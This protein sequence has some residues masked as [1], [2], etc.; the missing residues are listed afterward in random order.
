MEEKK[1]QKNDA[2]R[3]RW[4]DLDHKKVYIA[5]GIL[6]AVIAL[7]VVLIA[8]AVSG[9]KEKTAPEDPVKTEESQQQDV[10]P[11]VA[12]EPENVLEVDAYE[13]VNHLVLN[14]YDGIS[15][16]NMELVA[17]CVD[18]LTE[19]DQLTI[20]KKKDYIESYQDITCYTKKGLDDHSYV[21][22]A[23]FNMK[24]YNIETPAPGIQALYVYEN[25]AG[26]LKIFYEEATEELLAYVSQ[27]EED[28]EVAA[29]IADV[30]DRYQQLITEDEDLGKFVEVMLKSQETETEVAEEPEA[31]A[32]ETVEEPAEE[33]QEED[34][35]AENAEAT[36]LNKK[37]QLT[38]AV[39]IRADR[40][41]ESDILKNAYK[42]EIVTAI[43]SYSDG[44]SKV[45]YNGTVGY[46]KTEFLKDI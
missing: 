19:E 6:I 11:E 20:E 40:S 8:N 45:D 31:P 21:V 34:Q 16:G 18:V 32:D 29:V 9:N 26:E 30:N 39:R 35:P 13:D 33:P 22:F 24:I 7:I 10:I 38:D 23:S 14:Y 4:E 46:C 43:E 28:E 17:Q 36:A 3:I 5:I 42:S 25:E 27:L 2:S 41:T 37:M 15:S 44:W 1:N 12:E